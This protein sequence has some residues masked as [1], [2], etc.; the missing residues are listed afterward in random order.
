MDME[1]FVRYSK[2]QVCGWVCENYID[3]IYDR[4]MRTDFFVFSLTINNVNK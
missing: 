3:E 4:I 2:A 1:H